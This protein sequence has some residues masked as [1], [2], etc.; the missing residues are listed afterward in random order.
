MKH[1]TL[2][3]SDDDHDGNDSDTDFDHEEGVSGQPTS[4]D[5]EQATP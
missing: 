5:H 1:G 3:E 2:L 4:K